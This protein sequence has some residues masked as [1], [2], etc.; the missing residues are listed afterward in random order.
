MT[1]VQDSDA[2]AARLRRIQADVERQIAD[3]IGHGDR[4]DIEGAGRPLPSDPDEGSG[5]RWAA[6]HV[7]RN[8][9][10]VPE[11]V[12]L[13][14]RIFRERDALVGRVRAHRGALAARRTAFRRLPTEALLE[15]KRGT[16]LA[17]RRFAADLAEAV[18]EL[19]RHIARH[20]LLVR[21]L[22]L[23]LPSVSV[24]RIYELAE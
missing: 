4:D 23:Q 5:E 16:E 22:P 21:P 20:N 13:R 1:K 8:A 2:A 3:A 18:A 19:N 12:E 7:L 11:W 24:A 9:A 6:L 14:G 15:H 17:E 10:A